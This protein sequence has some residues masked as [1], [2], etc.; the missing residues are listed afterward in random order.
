MGRFALVGFRA[1]SNTSVLAQVHTGD[2]VKHVRGVLRTGLLQLAGAVN[3]RL[4]GD[5]A[6]AGDEDGAGPISRLFCVERIQNI[7][8]AE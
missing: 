5:Q 4:D 7:E 2:A 3:E 8:N 1:L 6:V